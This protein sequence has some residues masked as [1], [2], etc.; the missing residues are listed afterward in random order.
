[1]KTKLILALVL[2]LFLAGCELLKDATSVTI[3]TNLTSNIP[4]TVVQPTKGVT[5]L[6]F[7]KTQELM[8]SSNADLEPYLSKIEEITLNGVVITVSGLQAGQTINSVALDVAGVGNIFTQTN[9]TS[10]NNSFTPNVDAAK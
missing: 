1:M 8:L 10:T 9:I 2:P 4:V 5:A 6:S 3:D 7:T